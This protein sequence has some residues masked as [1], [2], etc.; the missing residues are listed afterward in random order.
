MNAHHEFRS[1]AFFRALAAL[2]RERSGSVFGLRIS[3]PLRLRPSPHADFRAALV[4]CLGVLI[5]GPSPAWGQAQVAGQAP[6]PSASIGSAATSEDRDAD[7]QNMLV[8]Y[9][10]LKTY[11]KDHGKLPDWLSDLVPKYIQDTNVLVSPIFR[12]SGKEELYGNEDPHITT[13]YIYEFSAKP[14]PE[15]IRGAF[16][17]LAAGTTMREWKTKQITEFGPVVPILRCFLH[18]P[19]LNVTS[20]GEF[21][22]SGAF[23]ETDPKTLELRKKR[24]AAGSKTESKSDKP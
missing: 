21:F 19:V 12:R 15:V 3:G 6:G 5:G 9:K 18:N 7:R 4:M 23:W 2:S 24:L 14:V 22:E 10:A 11:E 8:I 16:P 13:S 20:D 17:Q 1:S